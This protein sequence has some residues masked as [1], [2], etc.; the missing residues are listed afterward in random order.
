MNFNE[1]KTHLKKGWRAFMESLGFKY[2]SVLDDLPVQTGS[3]KCRK[4]GS[5]TWK[6]AN[7]DPNQHWLK[8]DVI[9]CSDCTPGA[10]VPK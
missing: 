3:N 2:R 1:A 8:S 7:T 10:G 6:A 9:E 4:C 5:T